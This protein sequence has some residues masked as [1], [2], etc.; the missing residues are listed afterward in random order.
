MFRVWDGWII[1]FLET[2][3]L[4]FREGLLMSWGVRLLGKGWAD[5]CLGCLDLIVGC[6]RAAGRPSRDALNPKP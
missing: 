6:D 5:T 4:G 2:C 1:L 3:G